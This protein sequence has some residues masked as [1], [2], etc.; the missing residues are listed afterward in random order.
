MFPIMATTVPG[1]IGAVHPQL[2]PQVISGEGPVVE[3]AGALAADKS[4][5]VIEV[6]H[7]RDELTR[8]RLKVMLSS[9][10]L[11][12]VFNAQPSILKDRIDL[13]AEEAS[14]REDAVKAVTTL[15]DEAQFL[16]A[17][18]FTIVSG[19]DTAPEKR[20]EARARLAESIARL[21]DEGGK[22]GLTV[23][24]E[25]YD[26]EVEHNRL[27]GPVAEAVDVA[28]QVKR[29]NFGLTLDLAHIILLREK[30]VDAVAA[31]RAYT[32]HAQVSNCVQAEGSPVRGDKHPA[33]GVEG[34][35]VGVDQVADFLRAL[36]KYGFHKK[37]EGGI[38][39]VEVRP[40]EE[41]YSSVVLAGALRVI[42][43][44]QSRL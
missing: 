32:V 3:T 41:E 30:I 28:K 18:L 44:A 8:A 36:D 38:V 31:A 1:R 26:R 29:D 20:A 12:V 24:L 4:L 5:N 14:A 6:T 42:A 34:S 19:P 7:V 9:G 40:R 11:K 10:A 43:E 39:T 35:L 22:R 37:P 13:G 33:F 25:P 16:G 17:R 27:V 2:Y 21:C 23:S 15:M